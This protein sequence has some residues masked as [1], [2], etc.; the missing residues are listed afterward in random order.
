MEF[1]PFSMRDSGLIYVPNC[2]EL[3]IRV[4]SLT[5]LPEQKLTEP[6]PDGLDYVLEDWKAAH[7]EDSE[8]LE[9]PWHCAVRM[10]QDSSSTP[11]PLR[12]WLQQE[13]SCA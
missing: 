9:V 10:P 3:A 13:A 6:R 11:V 5:A 12:D 2:P 1:F 4:T 7:T 8:L